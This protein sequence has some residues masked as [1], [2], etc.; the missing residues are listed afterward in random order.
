MKIADGTD[1]HQ[2]EAWLQQQRDPTPRRLGQTWTPASLCLQG[3]PA[4]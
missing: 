4:A 1:T 3:A 2:I